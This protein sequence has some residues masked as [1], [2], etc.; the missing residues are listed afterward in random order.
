MSLSLDLSFD[1]LIAKEESSESEATPI[2]EL[3]SKEKKARLDKLVQLRANKKRRLSPEESVGDSAADDDRDPFQDSDDSMSSFIDSDSQNEMGDDDDNDNDDEEEEEADAANGAN[4][5]QHN[6]DNDDEDDEESDGEHNRRQLAMAAERER[7]NKKRREEA[8]LSEKQELSWLQQEVVDMAD[9]EGDDEAAV[10]LMP[11]DGEKKKKKK[12]K[13]KEKKEHK[14]TAEVPW[15]IESNARHEKIKNI[16]MQDSKSTL[17][18]EMLPATDSA[19]TESDEELLE[20]AKTKKEREW[21][22]FI[23]DRTKKRRAELAKLAQHD[24]HLRHQL[25]R[26][27]RLKKRAREIAQTSDEAERK[28]YLGL[29]LMGL[30]PA[31]DN[32]NQPYVHQLVG[33][34]TAKLRETL[35]YKD[36]RGGILADEMGLGKTLEI[37]MLVCMDRLSGYHMPVVQTGSSKE[38]HAP[39]LVI[40]PTSLFRIWIDECAARVDPE[41]ISIIA[42][43]NQFTPDW[44]TTLRAR[45]LVDRD[46][47]I[48]NYEGLRNIYKELKDELINDIYRHPRRYER[49]LD[50]LVANEELDGANVEESS[51]EEEGEEATP[52]VPPHIGGSS[53][54]DIRQRLGVNADAE[55][56]EAD[57]DDEEI[58]AQDKTTNSK[59]A[60]AAADRR[61]PSAEIE[62]MAKKL[63][64]K[65][66]DVGFETIW[67]DHRKWYAKH[68]IFRLRFRRRVLDECTYIKKD[69]T[70]NFQAVRATHAVS[71]WGVSGTPVENHVD[72]LYSQLVVTGLDNTAHSIRDKKHW[73]RL[74]RPTVANG[75]TMSSSSSSYA[76][77]RLKPDPEAVEKLKRRFLNVIQIRREIHNNNAINP[78]QP[79]LNRAYNTAEDRLWDRFVQERAGMKRER[80]LRRAK[81]LKERRSERARKN[82]AQIQAEREDAQ[83]AFAYDEVGAMLG[84]RA[85]PLPSSSEMSASGGGGGDHYSHPDNYFP[86]QW[87]TL[88]LGR[89]VAHRLISRRDDDI[90]DLINNRETAPEG[91]YWYTSQAKMVRSVA[92][93]DHWMQQAFD[94]TLTQ[95]SNSVNAVRA[96]ITENGGPLEVNKYNNQRVELTMRQS[97]ANDLGLGDPEHP[98]VKRRFNVMPGLPLP[99]PLIFVADQHTL[100]RALNDDAL[101]SASKL[102]KMEHT[103]ETMQ[104]RQNIAF[105]CITQLRAGCVD[106]RSARNAPPFFQR[107]EGL[108]WNIDGAEPYTQVKYADMLKQ[109]ADEDE[110]LDKLALEKANTPSSSN[111]SDSAMT[112]VDAPNANREINGTVDKAKSKGSTFIK[113]PN[114]VATKALMALRYIQAAPA[115]D[116]FI[117]FSDL[118]ACMP[119][120]TAFFTAHG[121]R[122]VCI[123]GSMS[124]AAREEVIAR[125]KSKNKDS[126]RLLLAS[127]RCANMGI[128]LQVANHVM[129][130]TIWYNGAVDEQAKRRALRN[131]QEK[132]VYFIYFLLDETIEEFVLAR[133]GEKSDMIT[134]VVGENDGVVTTSSNFSRPDPNHAHIMVF[135]QGPYGPIVPKDGWAEKTMEQICALP[136][137]SLGEHFSTVSISQIISERGNLDHAKLAT[138]LIDNTPNRSKQYLNPNNN[139][140][141]NQS[142]PST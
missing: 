104:S 58:K 84:H 20:G 64:A 83:L 35:E 45:D 74:V 61:A 71:H 52:H 51:G 43:H 75:S 95:L 124:P 121:I 129:F 102:Q 99:K 100:E 86:S 93:V 11:T 60:A 30:L 12:K 24:E 101:E 77:A 67:R 120:M 16:L 63:T 59:K 85:L 73:H 130:L 139:N 103:P 137:K 10:D 141:K 128:N 112:V 81:A 135:D 5:Q 31:E 53:I 142:K 87:W 106:Y 54:I 21:R 78:L 108:L 90:L 140:K 42:L 62:R 34:A 23:I 127:L 1:G 88:P 46:I 110:E 113:M 29:R 48:I 125:F 57:V 117:A 28:R 7:E 116:K 41:T 25:E 119:T 39:T 114:R 107:T 32:T 6:K 40:C 72:E 132:P 55:E 131:G 44:R 133:G 70:M 14:P 17:E 37:I 82:Q 122:T 47:I 98:R 136:T 123:K 68:V 15:A 134:A 97:L 8:L 138:V 76:S 69:T 111:T 38:T 50:E 118:V 92:L 109:F 36:V 9:W 89:L 96:L 19:L 65:N 49:F 26:V 18:R 13:K 126:P 3:T 56:D 27:K 33:L 66:L 79:Y 94:I 105:R 22:L 91:F 2:V 115:D 80:A 4:P